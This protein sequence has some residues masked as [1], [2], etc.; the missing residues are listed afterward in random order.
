M[1][2][3]ADLVK[4]LRSESTAEDMY[5]WRIVEEAAT[6][7]ERIAAAW[8]EYVA[9]NGRSETHMQGLRRA[10]EGHEP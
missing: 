9:H 10:I 6:R 7:L 1:T 2:D 3:I 5:E 8:A 4:R